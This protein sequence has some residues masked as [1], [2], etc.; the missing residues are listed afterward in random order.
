[1]EVEAKIGRDGDFE[2]GSGG[3]R[4]VDGVDG[5]HSVIG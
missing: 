4:P 2:C 3:G 1:L 5:A